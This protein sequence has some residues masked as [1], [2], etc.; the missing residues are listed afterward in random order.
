MPRVIEITKNWSP[1]PY[2]QAFWNAVRLQGKKRAIVFAHRRWGKDEC[3][4]Q[5]TFA[6]ICKRPG[7]YWHMLPIA[8]QAR[9][10]IWAAVDESEDGPTSG[11]RRID[12]A[13]PK[14]FRKRTVE[15]EMKI[16]FCNGAT[17]QVIGSDNFNSLVGSSPVGIVFSEWALA[18]QEA[19]PYLRPILARN[20][21]YA[22]F[23]TT[24]RG[25]NHAW[26]MLEEVAKK[27]PENWY[28]E[29]SSV[30]GIER[31]GYKDNIGT[32]VYSNEE[33]Y[34]NRDEMMSEFGDDQGS[35][36]FAQEFECSF[37]AAILGA[38]FS[39]ALRHMEAE[40]R[41]CKIPID[42]NVRVH[43]AW[44]LGRNDATAIWFIQCVGR[45]RRLVDYYENSLT[46]L[47][48]YADKLYE[49]KK[50]RKWV[51]GTHYFPHDIQQQ[52]LN[53]VE[54]RINTLANLGISDHYI[55]PVHSVWEG[56]HATR[57]ML[58]RT[59]I[60]PERCAKGLE[61][62]K[63]YRQEWNDKTKDWGRQPVHDW[64]SHA[65][66][67]LRQ[68]AAGFDEPTAMNKLNDRSRPF[69]FGRKDGG[70]SHWSA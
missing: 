46:S 69:G 24:P 42:R 70:P 39:E 2:Q 27:D 1:K 11:K 6:Q 26:K 7:N 28:W 10:A 62:L 12:I 49:L 64:S 29:V 53:E 8:E 44:D 14:E 15:N 48:H 66:D 30:K 61:A 23:I 37:D 19:W 20:N 43:T 4:L 54:S 68:F 60:D 36:Y 22:I 65:A 3:V 56:I 45:E 32:G 17:W 16:E 58:D 59:L 67:A 47:H 38:F 31:H 9:K 13:F 51:Y 57:R 33:L 25:K 21:G 52:H 55:V 63:A 41:V 35:A 50:E 18:K 40:G 34:R 5:Y